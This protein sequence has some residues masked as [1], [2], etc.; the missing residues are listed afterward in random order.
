MRG[1]DVAEHGHDI[2]MGCPAMVTYFIWLNFMSQNE[3]MHANIILQLRVLLKMVV[4][5]NKNDPV[6]IAHKAWQQCH[7]I[8]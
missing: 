1:H 7:Y 5:V 6:S 2:I 4:S 8:V 3:T